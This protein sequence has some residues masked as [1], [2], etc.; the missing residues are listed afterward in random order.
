MTYSSVSAVE[1]KIRSVQNVRVYALLSEGAPHCR[2]TCKWHISL[3]ILS[4]RVSSDEVTSLVSTQLIGHS[5][6]SLAVYLCEAIH[7]VALRPTVFCR[8]SHIASTTTMKTQ[9]TKYSWK[10]KRSRS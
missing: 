7:N 3:A 10:F 1:Y 8:P 2:I 5:P 9:K 4:C 6:S